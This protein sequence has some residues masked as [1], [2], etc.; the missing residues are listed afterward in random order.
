M[1]T[2]LPTLFLGLLALTLSVA[3][4]D[5][6]Q[7]GAIPN[8]GKDDTEA[9][10]AAFSAAQ[11]NS[12]KL[13]VIPAGRYDLRADGNPGD[14]GALFSLAHVEGLTVQGEK[15]EF[16][17]K[18][19]GTLFAFNQCKNITVKGLTV[20]WDRPAFSQGTVI[21]ATP[22]SFDVQVETNFPVQGGEPV[23]A[24]MSYDPATRL[25]AGGGLDVYGGVERTE[26]IRP[27]VLR[28]HLGRHIPVPVGTLLV[29]RHSV[30]GAALLVFHR[31]ADVQVSDVTVFTG[32]GMGL[33][34]SVSTNIT[35]KNFNILRR[36]DSG[37]MMS[38]SADATHFGGCKGTIALEDCTFEGMGDDGVN[39]KSGLYLTVRQRLDDRT[40]LCQHNLKMVDL[41]D[42]GDVLELSHTDTLIPFASCRVRSAN[43]EPG[44]EHMHRVTFEEALPTDLRIGDVLGNATRAPKFRMLRCTVRGNRARGVLC[45]TRD[46][47]IEDCTFRNCTSAGVLVLTEVKYFYESIGTRNVTVRNSLFENC[48]QGA[49]SAG[50]ALAALA[51]LK[52]SAYPPKPGVHRDVCFEGNRII[53][54]SGT[55][56][57]AVGVDGLTIRSNTVEQACLKPTRE[58]GQNAIR[59]MNCARV[60]MTENN[61]DPKKQSSGMQE[62]VRV[63]NSDITNR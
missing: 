19:Y 4:V 39:V 2:A 27:Q 24:F 22:N 55:A 59:V 58:N 20:D 44:K 3:A 30:Y 56:I 31:C 18:G 16:M 36:P 17:M 61:V 7:H 37:R 5:V 48:N 51:W 32:P 63:T 21:A 54:T 62:P 40:V 33:V 23:G 49:A 46:A 47:L 43:L 15:A 35:L 1:K 50:G 42:A 26:L 45:Q 6:T 10:L 53:G 14:R 9:F 11:T 57:F 60:S 25:P 12:D 34:G 8:D 28:V 38:T 13:I 29:L 52:D 41:P